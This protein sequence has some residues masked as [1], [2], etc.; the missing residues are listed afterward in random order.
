MLKIRFFQTGSAIPKMKPRRRL[1]TAL[2]IIATVILGLS[3][4]HFPQIFPSF[5]STYGGD[6]LWAANVFFLIIFLFP[7][8][9]TVRAAVVALGVSVLVELSQFYHAPWIDAIRDTTLGGLA[10]GYGFLWSDL[11]CYAA[12]VLLA[13]MV[14][15]WLVKGSG[16][17]KSRFG[18]FS[19]LAKNATVQNSDPRRRPDRGG[20]SRYRSTGGPAPR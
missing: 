17:A 8:V 9:P 12:G 15:F 3:S 14:D 6:A 19:R 10:L 18:G 4:R 20:C 5:F 16:L 13:L 7:A 11:A 1:T 2:L